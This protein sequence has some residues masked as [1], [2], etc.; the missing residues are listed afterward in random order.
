MRTINSVT[1]NMKTLFKALYKILLILIILIFCNITWI[2]L[3]F[4]TY[5]NHLSDIIINL[6]LFVTFYLL[7]KLIQNIIT[8]KEIEKS[9]KKEDI[10]HSKSKINIYSIIFVII[11]ELREFYR[12]IKTKNIFNCILGI[13][14]IIILC[15]LAY[16][17]SYII[18]FL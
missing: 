18:F 5:K 15:C 2:V 13:I 8:R 1:I 17:I 3:G 16:Y 9:L 12:K 6:T 14:I 7:I 4:I 11:I 10:K